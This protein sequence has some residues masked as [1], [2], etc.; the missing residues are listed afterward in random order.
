[1]VTVKK[2]SSQQIILSCSQLTEHLIKNHI[3][4]SVAIHTKLPSGITKVDFIDV[5]LINQTL[6]VVDSYTSEVI[7]LSKYFQ[8]A[9]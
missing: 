7:T 6:S 5:S 3:G 1:M 2:F 9:A 4:D 8:E